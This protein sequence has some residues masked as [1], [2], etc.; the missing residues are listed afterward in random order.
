VQ[1]ELPCVADLA[2]QSK[3]GCDHLVN[4]IKKRESKIH[5][6]VNN[7][8]A[9]WGAPWNNFPESGWDK[10]LALNVKS[11]FYSELFSSLP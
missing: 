11:L 8:G 5:I 7:S 10:V 4:E 2:P 1:I 3:A 6:L 9:T